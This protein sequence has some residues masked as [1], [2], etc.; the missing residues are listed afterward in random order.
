MTPT[1]NQTGEL[2][3]AFWWSIRCASSSRKFSPSCLGGEVAVVQAPVGDG[4]DDA[5]D[6]FGDAAFALGR[7]QLAVEIFAGDDVGGGLRPV[8]GDFDVALLED[9]RAFIVADGGGAGFPL[10]LVV[11]RLAVVARRAVK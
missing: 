9:D 5:M 1:L 2:K 10:H 4:V 7:A 6:Q 11:G 3:A 8:G